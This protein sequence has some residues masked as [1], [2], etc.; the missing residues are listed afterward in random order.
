MQQKPPFGSEIAQRL[1]L[2]VI[3]LGVREELVHPGTRREVGGMEQLD[4]DQHERRSQKTDP[5]QNLLHPAIR[6]PPPA[7]DR[8]HSLVPPIRSKKRWHFHSIR[9]RIRRL[10]FSHR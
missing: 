10:S 2:R 3:V 9:T 8:G 6:G 5:P 7:I 1:V 4:G